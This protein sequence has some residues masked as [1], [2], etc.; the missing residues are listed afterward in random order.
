MLVLPVSVHC[1][2]AL[3][4]LPCSEPPTMMGMMSVKE[5]DCKDT[6]APLGKL[7]LVTSGILVMLE[8]AP[9]AVVVAFMAG[10]CVVVFCAWT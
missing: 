8:F 9:P 2:T 4:K 7:F 1:S 6:L 10:D 3:Y 5:L